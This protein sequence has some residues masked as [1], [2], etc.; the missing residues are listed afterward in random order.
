M[1]DYARRLG[2]ATLFQLQGRAARNRER[3]YSG[4]TGLRILVLHDIPP[5]DFPRFQGLVEWC[6]ERFDPGQPDDADALVEGHYDPT[7]RDRILFTFDDGLASHHV[8]ADWLARRGLRACFFI[9]PSLLGRSFPEFL[10]HHRQRGVTATK[11]YDPESSPLSAS[12][13]LEI[14]AM[15]HRVGAHND[16]HRD[17]AGLHAPEELD[18]EIGNALS[19]V[20]DLLGARCA[21]FAIGFGQPSNLSTEAAGNLRD[22]DGRVFAA[23]RGLNV[24]GVTPRFLLRG[25]V[26]F[27]YPSAFTKVCI[28]GGA[29]HLLAPRVLELARLGGLTPRSPAWAPLEDVR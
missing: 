18:Y 17:L 12:Q 6:L 5:R 27:E 28:E 24:P 14:A 16:A 29:D 19:Q 15:G 2:A 10:A 1:M 21:D 11:F 8:A 20:G 3:L 4:S 9:V 7:P 25:P 26:H 23:V 22:F 13:A